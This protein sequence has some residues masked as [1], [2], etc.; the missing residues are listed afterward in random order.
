MF[1]LQDLESEEGNEIPS[2]G[3][4]RESAEDVAR[5]EAIRVQLAH[6]PSREELQASGEFV[7][8]GT[9]ES[10]VALCRVQRTLRELREHAQLSVAELGARTGLS[11]A[12]IQQIESGPVAELSLSL[13]NRYAASFG[14]QIELEVADLQ[15]QT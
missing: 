8:V 9:M 15:T 10:Y 4:D 2:D 12:A 14:K 11:P 13:I 1:R 5:H 3:K 7:P 6:K